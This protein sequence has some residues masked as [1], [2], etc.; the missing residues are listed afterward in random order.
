MMNRCKISIG[1]LLALVVLCVSSLFIL[2]HQCA[3]FAAQADTVMEAVAAGETA[4]ALADCE[5]LMERWEQFHD[6]TGVFVDGARLDVLR[7]ILAGL[8]ALIAQE[9]PEAMSQLETLRLLAEDIFLEE[10]PDWWHI[11]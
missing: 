10:L 11:L 7:E 5:V 9:H 4:Q 2:R 6:V 1:V 3:G 8:P